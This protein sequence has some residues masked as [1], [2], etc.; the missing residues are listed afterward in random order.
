[1]QGVNQRILQ[2]AYLNI[3]KQSSGIN[4]TLSYKPLNLINSQK[5]K[6]AIKPT[7]SYIFDKVLLKHYLPKF[8]AISRI[9]CTFSLLSGSP[10][11]S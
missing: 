8:T 5:N 11:S 2:K 3:F 9:S 4:R 7:Y 10:V 6:L 1:M